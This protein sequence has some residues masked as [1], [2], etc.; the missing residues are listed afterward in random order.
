[1][2][3]GTINIKNVV[4]TILAIEKKH[5]LLEWKIDNVFAWQSARVLIYISLLDLIIPTDKAVS[6]QTFSHRICL[7]FKRLIINSIIYNPYFDFTKS[8]ILVFDSGRKY[9]TDGV[10]IDIYTKY[11]CDELEQQKIS[12]T[13]YNTNYQVDSLTPRCFRVKHL[14]FILIASQLLSKILN[15]RLSDQDKSR[16]KLVEDVINDSFNVKLNLASILKNEIFIFKSQYPFFKLLFKLKKPSNIYLINSCNKSPLIKA[17][18]DSGIIVNELQHGLMVKEDLVTHFPDVPEDSLEYFPDKFF[19]WK[20]LYMY[21]SKLPLSGKYIINSPNKHL[22][23][24]VE[25]NTNIKRNKLQILIVSQ[26]FCS[27]E[28]LKF[29]M[30]NIGDLPDYKFVYK[31][32]PVENANFSI[33]TF[34]NQFSKYPNISFIS[35]QESIYKLFS[36][37]EFVIGINSAATFEA[38]YFGCKI[39]LLN[40]PGVEMATSLIK[41]GKAKLIDIDNKLSQELY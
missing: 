14:D 9:L 12:Y 25:N 36:E 31:L 13:R 7:Y 30:K 15:V 20:D 23:H 35:N 1:M 3:E 40:L 32:H 34:I 16:M 22:Q 38:A 5:N 8:E 4:D 18:K 2:P 33:A 6:R 21:T 29:V 17:A 24:M 41:D 27:Q 26:P 28:I 11:L 39:I 19:I 10:Y 37:S